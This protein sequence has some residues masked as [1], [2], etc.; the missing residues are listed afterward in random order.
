MYYGSEFSGRFMGW[1][2]YHHHVQI[3]FSRPGKPTDRF[4]REEL[5]RIAAG[6]YLNVHW[7]GEAREKLS[8]RVDYN[9]SRL[10]KVSRT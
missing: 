8:W 10:T 3:N 5:Q 4:I 6:R 2:A 1:R 9:V 7:F